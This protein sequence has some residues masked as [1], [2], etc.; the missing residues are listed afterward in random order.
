MVLQGD[1]VK[2]FNEKPDKERVFISGGFFVMN[3]SIRNYM[4]DD[5]QCIF[6]M[7][8]LPVLAEK[9]DLSVY[10]H[11]GFWQCMDTYREQMILEELWQSGK[12]P[13]KIW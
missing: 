6:E 2:T 9:G 7:A 12:A 5:D 1:C 11:N 3:K 13:W 10:R 8:V 4:N